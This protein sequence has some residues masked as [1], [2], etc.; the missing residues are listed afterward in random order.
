MSDQEKKDN[1]VPIRRLDP[2]KPAP[3]TTRQ[4]DEALKPINVSDDQPRQHFGVSGHREGIKRMIDKLKPNKI[5]IPI[6]SRLVGDFEKDV[7]TKSNLFSFKEVIDSI[8][9]DPFA[10]K[11]TPE[12]QRK[13]RNSCLSGHM[14][15]DERDVCRW[16]RQARFNTITTG[17]YGD[18][19]SLQQLIECVAFL[20]EKRM[21]EDYVFVMQYLGL[22]DNADEERLQA[23]YRRIS[24][25]ETL[26]RWGY[27]NP[28][29]H[30]VHHPL[31]NKM[32]PLAALVS[33]K[34][35]IVSS[36]VMRD[37]DMR[38]LYAN[39][40]Y[41][42]FE[43]HNPEEIE[44]MVRR[45]MQSMA[46]A[47]E[48]HQPIKK[49]DRYPDV[50]VHGLD[51]ANTPLGAAPFLRAKKN[52]DGKSSLRLEALLNS[53]KPWLTVDSLAAHT[54]EEKRHPTKPKLE[55]GYTLRQS[56]K[57]HK[58]GD[59]NA[60]QFVRDVKPHPLLKGLIKKTEK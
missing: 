35:A 32:V 14:S 34:T 49:V 46:A 44:A 54:R 6:G 27:N 7:L 18:S 3:L 45:T 37:D 19:P 40:V 51:I 2:T 15:D 39:A 47:A 23:Y 12:A 11:S 48:V 4:I 50:A 43:E 52:L 9:S 13:L 42:G 57:P 55:A 60:Q 29:Q 38:D 36:L 16:C 56:P 31:Q 24:K 59:K 28:S 20:R 10:A 8:I 53:I 30:Y 17:Y 5:T 33:G 25:L 41:V 22:P 21:A 1:V 58:R 26:S